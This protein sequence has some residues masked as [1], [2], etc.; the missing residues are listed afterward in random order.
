MSTTHI[1]Y[2][3]DTGEIVRGGAWPPTAP[4]DVIEVKITKSNEWAAGADGWVWEMIISRG[5][6]GSTPDLVLIATDCSVDGK[7]VTLTFFATAAQTA[8]LQAGSTEFNVDIRS[9]EAGDPAIPSYY[10]P[11]QG[12]VQVRDPVGQ[13]S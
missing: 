8:E 11:A 5:I 12:T 2:T 7:V 6:R 13:G 3:E 1:N 4:H 10:D 9:T